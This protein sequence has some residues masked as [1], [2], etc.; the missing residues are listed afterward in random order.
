MN[1]Y[2]ERITELFD[3][4]Y[5]APKDDKPTPNKRIESANEIIEAYIGKHGERPPKSILSR[6]ATY[7]LLDTLTDS[8]PDKM[9]R[10][11][12]PIIST[13][14][15]FRRLD[16]HK[17]LD[18]IEY[19]GREQ[20]GRRKT[21]FTDDYGAPQVRNN[22][23]ASPYEDENEAFHW[24]DLID[25]IIEGAKLTD[26][27]REIVTKL[28]LEERTQAEVSAELGI[29][30]QMIHRHYVTAFDKMADYAR[31]IGKCKLL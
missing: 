17:F 28:F 24:R 13:K 14:Q 2:H 9:S 29:S 31:K 16:R 18:N 30:R 27:Q 23:M 22:R 10:E 5:A 19:G 7:I 12:Y 1:A 3:D 6:L 20:N 4:Y 25:S 11:E 15:L 26:R 21:S 8:H